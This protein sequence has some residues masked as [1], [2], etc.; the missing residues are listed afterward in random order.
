ML[1]IAILLTLLGI[2]I[3]QWTIRAMSYEQ[4]RPYILERPL[5]IVLVYF[6]WI[7]LT[8]CGLYLFWQINYLVVFIIIGFIIEIIFIVRYLCSFEF[9]AR[10]ICRIY[11]QL[12][13]QQPLIDEQV[14]FETTARLFFKNLG[15]SDYE[16]YMV[17]KFIFMDNNI[18]SGK[19]IKEVIRAVLLYENAENIS[20]WNESKRRKD[21]RKKAIELAMQKELGIDTSTNITSTDDLW[22]GIDSKTEYY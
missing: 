17:N 16:V 7:S 19:N 21:K 10:K 8:I 5:T 13:Q 20:F 22:V 12:K 6:L 4:S 2:V 1:T 18:S 3:M 9:K 14:A 15:W 11:K